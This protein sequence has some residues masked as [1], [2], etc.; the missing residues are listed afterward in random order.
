M[1]RVVGPDLL[2]VTCESN[3]NLKPR[4]ILG[5]FEIDTLD[6]PNMVILNVLLFL[7]LFCIFV[8]VFFGMTIWWETG[9]V[10]SGEVQTSAN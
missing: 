5:T 10:R 2:S 8:F 1:L 7:H 3:L 4:C 9:Q 6:V